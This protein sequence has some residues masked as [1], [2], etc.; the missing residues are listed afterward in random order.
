M[1]KIICLVG[2]SGVGKTTIA[3]EL[4]KEGYNIIHSYT[5]REPRE[6]NEW[7]HIF[8]SKSHKP[9][10]DDVIAYQE[11]YGKR[12][13]AMKHQYQGKG[14]SIY[15]IDPKGVEQ[16]KKQVK[17]AEIVTIFLYADEEERASRM[18]LQGR[19]DIHERLEKDEKLFKKVYCDVA[20]DAN[21]PIEEVLE[22]VKDVIDE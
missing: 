14:I 18:E 5:D 17:D 22:L 16:I 19:K 1:D 9:I 21:R 20:I 2:P 11:I 13:Y 6:P 7:G 12:Y 8:V 10:M 4:E 3:K 15:V